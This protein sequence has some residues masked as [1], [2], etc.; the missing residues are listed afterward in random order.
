MSFDQNKT[1]KFRAYRSRLDEQR[2][3]NVVIAALLI[4]A[5]IAMLV[6]EIQR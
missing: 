2:L 6:Y 3:F 1:G 5:L 4:L